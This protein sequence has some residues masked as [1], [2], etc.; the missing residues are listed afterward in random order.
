MDK[1]IFKTRRSIKGYT[2]EVITDEQ[3]AYVLEAGTY[4]PTGMNRQSPVI[5]AIKDKDTIEKLEREN[6]KVMGD[7][8]IKAFY[9]ATTLLVVFRDA[10]CFTGMEDACLV[11]GNMMNA[12]HA[13]GIG[14]CWIHRAKEVFE[15]EYGKSLMKKWGL[16]DNYK[17][18]GHCILG[19][20]KA[21]PQTRPRKEN[22]II[23]D[24]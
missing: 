10:N 14:S 7:E 22:Y 11:L 1:N 4:A 24:K 9:G 16:S 8:S 19:I 17:G 21:V 23:F 6:A 13:I 18:V 5:V 20:P 3:L 2:N 15:G 12:A